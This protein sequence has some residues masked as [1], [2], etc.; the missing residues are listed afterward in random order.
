MWKSLSGNRI[1]FG[2]EKKQSIAYHWNKMNQSNLIL[3]FGCKMSPDVHYYT[4][5]SQLTGFPDMG[6]K[7]HQGFVCDL[8]KVKKLCGTI[9]FFAWCY[10]VRCWYAEMVSRDH[11]GYGLSQWET[12]LQCNI[13][14]HWLS[15]YPKWC[16]GQANKL[17]EQFIV[18][19]K[20]SWLTGT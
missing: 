14:S 17:K 11:S 19:T 18:A 9:V 12:L 20:H 5:I 3:K 10:H 2:K 6:I 4:E 16:H 7:G 1:Q 13:I 8:L 15:P